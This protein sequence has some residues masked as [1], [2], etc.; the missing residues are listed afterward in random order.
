MLA[1]RGAAE[2][3]PLAETVQGIISARLDALSPEEKALLQDASV[4]GKVFW[5]GALVNGDAAARRLVEER[6]HGLE[7]KEFVQ[8]A[9]RSSVAGETEY[10]FRHLLLRDVAYGQIPRAARAERHRRGGP[11][12]EGRC[13]RPRPPAARLPR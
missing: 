10:A 3:L 6:L 8:R 4:H 13:A 1:E 9:R 2:E 12:G 5:A 7:R 11:G